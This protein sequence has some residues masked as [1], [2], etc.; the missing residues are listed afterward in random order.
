MNLLDIIIPDKNSFF[1]LYSYGEHLRKVYVKEKCITIITYEENSIVYLFYTYPTHREACIIRNS[2]GPGTL[3]PNL[4]KKIS[5]LFSVQAS[6]VDKLHRAFNYLNK[7]GLAYSLPDSFYLRLFYILSQ[8]GKIN[9]AAL[10]ELLE[11]TPKD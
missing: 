5:L 8:K 6:K 4:S 11:N 3:L 7:R 1:S 2:P 9:Y 10:R